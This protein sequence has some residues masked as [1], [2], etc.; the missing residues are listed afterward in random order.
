MKIVRLFLWQTT[1]GSRAQ[2]LHCCPAKRARCCSCTC[3]SHCLKLRSLPQKK[4][5]FAADSAA[6]F[7]QACGAVHQADCSMP[8]HHCVPH[9]FHCCHWLWPPHALHRTCLRAPLWH[10]KWRLAP[11]CL[12]AIKLLSVLRALHLPFHEAWVQFIVKVHEE[13]RYTLTCLETWSSLNVYNKIYFLSSRR[14][15]KK[16]DRSQNCSELTVTMRWTGILVQPWWFY[17][18]ELITFSLYCQVFALS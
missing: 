8:R 10:A 3:L 16:S 6:T 7:L 12:A 11:P 15:T 9:F 14:S 1:L 2:C 13:A 4:A 5:K 17:A 18:L